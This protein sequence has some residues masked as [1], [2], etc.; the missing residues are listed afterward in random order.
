[1]YLSEQVFLSLQLMKLKVDLQ[2]INLKPSWLLSNLHFF[3]SSEG[4]R[5]QGLK[6]GLFPAQERT[7]DPANTNAE[8]SA[9]LTV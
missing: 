7:S 9:W 2:T 3:L 6:R 4:P 1:M 8:D 5:R